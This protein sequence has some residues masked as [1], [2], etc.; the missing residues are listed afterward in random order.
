MD[1]NSVI[2]KKIP[3]YGGLYAYY[4]CSKSKVEMY[5][6]IENVPMYVCGMYVGV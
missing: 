6:S 5:G 4:Y 1:N 3:S 2:V